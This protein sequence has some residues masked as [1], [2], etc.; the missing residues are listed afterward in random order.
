MAEYLN[1][2]IAMF[3]SNDDLFKKKV[4]FDDFFMAT[5]EQ[6][7]ETQ[8]KENHKSLVIVTRNLPGYF[9]R[10]QWSVW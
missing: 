6:E 8:R 7:K 5:W 1:E 2:N 9:G 4:S 10:D 3:H